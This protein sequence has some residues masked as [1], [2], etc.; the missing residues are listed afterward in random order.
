MLAVFSGQSEPLS[1]KTVP[2]HRE[3]HG[4]RRSPRREQSS[5]RGQRTRDSNELAAIFFSAQEYEIYLFKKCFFSTLLFFVSQHRVRRYINKIM[6]V[7]INQAAGTDPIMP[8]DS[9]YSSESGLNLSSS[10]VWKV[11][12]TWGIWWSN[13]A[14]S[15]GL[16]SVCVCFVT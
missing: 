14:Y 9:R 1:M 12:L 4:Y 11:M 10:R 16:Y 6:R 3:V 7:R 8:S 5:R 2:D 15:V 13:T